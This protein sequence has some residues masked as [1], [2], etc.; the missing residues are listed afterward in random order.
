MANT[1]RINIQYSQAS[2]HLLVTYQNISHGVTRHLHCDSSF[3]FVLDS[4]VSEV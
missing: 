1:D 3:N 4:T 2:Q